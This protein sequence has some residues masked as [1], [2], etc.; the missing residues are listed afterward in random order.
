[1]RFII[2]GLICLLPLIIGCARKQT[3]AP[4]QVYT[5]ME[6]EQSLASTDSAQNVSQ[7]RR[8]Q[9]MKR[10]VDLSIPT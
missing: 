5:A 9:V 7:T 3:K 6:D 10:K 2:M 8:A 4:D 1:M